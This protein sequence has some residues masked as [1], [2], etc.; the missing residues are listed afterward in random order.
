MSREQLVETYLRGE[1]S[2]RVFMRRLVAAGVSLGAAAAYAQLAPERARAAHVAYHMDE[3]LGGS[4][5]TTQ[6]QTFQPLPS[7]LLLPP[8]PRVTTL[9]VGGVTL[10]TLRNRGLRVSLASEGPATVLVDLFL[11]RSRLMRGTLRFRSRGRRTATFRLPFRA[12]LRLRRMRRGRFALVTTT[13]DPFGRR[14]TTK[15]SFTAA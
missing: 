3:D 5:A 8:V 1:I 14:R 6:P 2:R 13:I 9:M 7:P 15:R 11:G 10:A 12:R 4:P